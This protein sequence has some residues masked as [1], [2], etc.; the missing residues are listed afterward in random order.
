MI[1]LDLFFTNPKM[2]DFATLYGKV[3]LDHGDLSDYHDLLVDDHQAI[4]YVLYRLATH[5]VTLVSDSLYL[6]DPI[7]VQ[8][9]NLVPPSLSNLFSKLINVGYIIKSKNTHYF[10]KFN[11][12]KKDYQLLSKSTDPYIRQFLAYIDRVLAATSP[13]INLLK[14]QFTLEPVFETTRSIVNLAD[15]NLIN[16]LFHA[17]HSLHDRRQNAVLLALFV[18]ALQ[19]ILI[20]LDSDFESGI[21][22]TDF[23]T[24]YLRKFK[25]IPI[26]LV[27]A[28]YK[29][30][31]WK[32]ILGTELNLIDSKV[33]FCHDK[34]RIYRAETA[35][36][37]ENHRRLIYDL[38]MDKQM[39]LLELY[40]AEQRK[41]LD[42]II[43]VMQLIQSNQ[44]ADL[45][46]SAAALTARVKLAEKQRLA[47]EINVFCFNSAIFAKRG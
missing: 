2:M 15:S 41:I 25:F 20:R 19:P 24:F 3:T 5:P 47:A 7:T 11:S 40:Q 34:C 32:N 33:E 8:H 38:E 29:S 43:K 27:Q 39:K 42:S 10:A 17:L 1:P 18:T 22:T 13:T 16:N 6:D 31:F 26:K 46:K 23:D 30:L 21:E 36:M 37:L 44:I 45:Q 12:F 35:R 28:I 4:L 14:L 9:I